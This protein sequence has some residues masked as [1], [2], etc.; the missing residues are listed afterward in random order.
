MAKCQLQ[1]QRQ[2]VEGI[3]GTRIW[4]FVPQEKLC[5]W[6][7]LKIRPTYFGINY[8]LEKFNYWKI[9]FI[10]N[11]VRNAYSNIKDN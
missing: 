9:Y 11:K 8:K 2:K 3:W 6:E 7:R 1:T 5:A 4:F 10:I